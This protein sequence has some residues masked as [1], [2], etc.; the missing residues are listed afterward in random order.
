MD[1]NHF[2]ILTLIGVHSN[3]IMKFN[4][5]LVFATILQRPVFVDV[6]ADIFPRP[7][8]YVDC[9]SLQNMLHLLLVQ[10]SVAHS[11]QLLMTHS[12]DICVLLS[13]CLF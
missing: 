10:V 4:G 12:V 3:I 9:G 11:F 5:I 7:A 1:K 8:L 13:V 2:I 6:Q